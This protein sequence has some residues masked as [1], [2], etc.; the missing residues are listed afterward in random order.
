MSSSGT[1]RGYVHRATG[2]TGHS[3][4]VVGTQQ[5]LYLRAAGTAVG[6]PEILITDAT[7]ESYEEASGSELV[8]FTATF[9]G[10]AATRGYQ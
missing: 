7:I 4:L 10:G 2:A 9:S 6:L 1:I 3:L 8:Q 5:D